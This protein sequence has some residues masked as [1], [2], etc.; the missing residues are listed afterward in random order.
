MLDVLI[1]GGLIVDGTGNP[2]YVADLGIS[3]GRIAGLGSFE[4]AEAAT[5]IDARGLA[6]AP[7]FIDMHSHSDLSLP[8]HPRARSSLLQGITTEVAGSC[9]WSPAPLKGEVA[10]TVL[11]M[12]SEGLLGEVPS[13]IAAGADDGSGPAWHSF[14]EY[15]DYLDKHGIGVNLYPIV[16][17][18]LI[19]A[20]IVGLDRR[21]A[22]PGEIE[23]M[24]ALTRA[25]LEE[26]A[27]GLSTGRSY[28]PG[29]S[30]S[31]AE[32]VA[33]ARVVA[34]YD[35]LYTSHVKDESGGV[36]EAVEEAVRIGREA[37]VRVEVSHHKAI[38]RENFGKVARTLALMEEA[39]REGI[40][41]TCDVYPYSFAQVFSLLGE[42]PGV[43]PRGAPDDVRASLGQ[44]EFRERAATEVRKAAARDGKLPGFLASPH[45]YLIVTAGRD[46]DLEG[47]A[48]EE[49]LGIEPPGTKKGPPDEA[50]IRR[51]VD[52]LADLL[53]E[54]D[55]KLHL[56]ALMSEDDVFAVLSH[57]ETM[58]GTD[59]FALDRELGERTPVHPRHFGTFPR[60]L[61]HYRR[62]RGLGDLAG[63]VHKLTALPARK[64]R[65]TDRGLLA[66]GG[67]ADVVVFDPETISDR[68]TG[69][70]PYLAPVGV[71][72][73]IVNGVMAVE[74][75]AVS[76]DRAGKVLRR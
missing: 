67:W 6:V 15:L 54:Q 65:L 5:V 46:A 13:Q 3:G 48:F 18:S 75:G 32:V 55:L 4:G 50:W 36:V 1:R 39:R 30:S 45:H 28:M 10:Q 9:G 61:G 58:V 43:T 22:T 41:I 47:R 63:V 23:A 37:G 49:V 17:Q 34:R 7:G 29:A 24:E 35:G 62:S 51:L 76:S 26:G 59:A 68:A 27:R 44:P 2:P 72:W 70:E 21:P 14:G 74:R 31:T 40:D 12:L 73:V 66:R 64:L 8:S 20:H 60:V 16:G 69:K 25:C 56:A 52:R 19:R 53:L 71:E 38:G 42:I 33:L 11:K 57:P